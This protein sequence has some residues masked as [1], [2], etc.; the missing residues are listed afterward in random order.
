MQRQKDRLSREHK[1]GSRGGELVCTGSTREGF[2][3]EK[4]FKMGEDEP[5]T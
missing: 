2:V 1:A 3:E 5:M 4:A